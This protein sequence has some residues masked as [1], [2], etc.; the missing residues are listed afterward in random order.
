MVESHGNSPDADTPEPETVVV[1]RRRRRW[2]VVLGAIGLVV[3]AAFLW[4]WLTRDEIAGNYIAAQLRK[5]GLRGTY[6]VVQIGPVH[7]ILRNVVIGDPRRPDLTVEE[8]AVNIRYRLGFPKVGVITAVRPRLYGSLHGGKWSFG[9]LDKVLFE[10][11]SRAP[12]RLPNLEVAIYDGRGLIDSDYGPIGVKVQGFGRLRHGFKGILAAFA[13]Q[14]QAG[15]CRLGRTTLFARVSIAHEQPRLEGPLRLAA[16]SCPDRNIALS[17]IGLELDATLDQSLRGGQGTLGLSSGAMVVG[18]NRA[19]GFNGTATLTYRRRGVTGK[20]NVLLRG[21][22]MGQAKATTIGTEGTLR[23]Q[24]GLANLEADGSIDAGGLRVGEALDATLAGFQR[25]TDRTLL[26]P[27]LGQIRAALQRQGPNSRLTASYQLRRSPQGDS[28]VVPGAALRGGSGET[29]LAL[30]RFQMTP[31]ANGGAPLISGNF[32]TGGT[33]LP[34]IA[35]RMER[36]AGQALLRLTMADYQAGNGRLAIPQL[37]VAQAPNGALGFAGTVALSGPLPGGSAQDLVLPIDGN[38]G[39]VGGLSLWRRCTAVRFASLTVGSL[40]LEHRDLTL[41]PPP[42]SAIVR[43][44]RGGTRI[45]AGMPSLNVAGRLGTTP[46]RIAA[47]PVGFTIPGAL[48]AR[49]LDVALGPAAT[50]TQFT[51]ANLTAKIGKEIAGR[52]DGT[53]A[54]LYAVPMDILGASG[55]WHY[56]AGKLTVADGTFRLI[57][58]RPAARFEPLVSRGATLELLDNIITAKALLREPAT[59]RPVTDVAIR[60]DLTRGTGHAD[61]AVPG[62]TFD[63]RLQPSN[64]SRLALGTIANANGT[65]RGSGRVD[66]DARGVT[67]S[68]RFSTASLDFAAPFGP[69]KGASGTIVFTDLIGMISAP[70]QHLHV[71]SVNPGIEVTDGDVVYELRPGALL[72]LKSATWPFLGGVLRLKPTELNLGVSETRHYTLEITGLDA[73]KFV[74]HMELANIKATGTFDGELPLVFDQNGGRIVNGV[75]TARPP[76]GNVSYVGELT[77]KDLSAMANFAFDA[78]KS[79]DYRT[80][81]VEMNGALEGEIV[82]RVRLSGV[83]QGAGAKRNFITQRFAKLPIQFNINVRA[84]FYQLITSYRSFNDPSLVRDPRSLGL[85]DEQGRPI[86][87]EAINPPPPRPPQPLKPPPRKRGTKRP[88]QPPVSEKKP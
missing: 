50:P 22:E 37:L 19:S 18:A 44:D 88:I 10:G 6:Q 16:L 21:L 34:R 27:M 51:L 86:R 38:W 87:V 68:G 84:P 1:V 65:I 12:F 55:A 73:A 77:Y 76:G 70:N 31:V 33:G 24:N 60:H 81:R 3:L 52:F 75:L 15:D 32:S 48:Y 7:Q 8:V 20:Y 23:T 62:L 71:A 72:A 39:K 54:K 42:G 5:Q 83:R 17:N 41:C 80:M 43:S 53:D 13:P 30:S 57:D 35:G 9:S 82:T 14:A 85:I 59:D 11:P 28:V 74:A 63:N 58:R 49:R 64:I 78:L 47:G 2:P 40:T 45:A 26:A 66:W 46:I 36:A 67:S 4:A 79:L 56:G 29:L 61:L 25:G 69:V